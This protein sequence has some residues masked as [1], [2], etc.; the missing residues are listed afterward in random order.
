MQF[1]YAF[2]HGQQ[3]QVVIAQDSDSTIAQGFDET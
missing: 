1:G 2:G 3:V